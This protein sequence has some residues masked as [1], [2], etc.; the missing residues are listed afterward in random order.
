MP[1]YQGP[2]TSSA[3][4]VLLSLLIVGLIATAALPA[5]GAPG[6][7]D[8]E[9]TEVQGVPFNRVVAAPLPLYV[10]EGVPAEKLD[11]TLEAM[12]IAWREV[13]ELTGLPRPSLTLP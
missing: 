3:R 10:T 9:R 4:R 7:V 13:P 1:G 8:L 12:Q 11:W 6:A 2:E 5:W